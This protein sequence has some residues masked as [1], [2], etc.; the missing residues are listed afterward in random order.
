MQV[1]PD[2]AHLAAPLQ[3]NADQQNAVNQINQAIDNHDPKVFLLQ[4]VTG[5]G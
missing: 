2:D 3:L 5:S 4:G 1:T